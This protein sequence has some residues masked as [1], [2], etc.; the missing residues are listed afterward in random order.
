MDK[1]KYKSSWPILVMWLLSITFGSFQ[2]AA[3]TGLVDEAIQRLEQDFLKDSSH[4]VPDRQDVTDLLQ[5]IKETSS[6]AERIR[7]MRW[8]SVSPFWAASI[9][10]RDYWSMFLRFS[11]DDQPYALRYYTGIAMI[12]EENELIT[13]IFNQDLETAQEF[14]RFNEET[15]Q[16]YADLARLAIAQLIVWENE[17][18][19]VGDAAAFSTVFQPVSEILEGVFSE[20][21]AQDFLKPTSIVQDIS[22]SRRIFAVLSEGSDASTWSGLYNE[23]GGSASIAFDPA[24]GVEQVNSRFVNP[25]RTIADTVFGRQARLCSRTQQRLSQ[26]NNLFYK[27]ARGQKN[28]IVNPVYAIEQVCMGVAENLSIGRLAME[29]SNTE[30]RDYRVVVGHTR[31][32]TVRF[33]KQSIDELATSSRVM[34]ENYPG[35]RSAPPSEGLAHCRSGVDPS[36]FVRDAGVNRFQSSETKEGYI[37]IGQGLSRSEAVSVTEFVQND[38]AFRGAYVFRPVD[39]R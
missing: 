13:S 39:R 24:L 20:R 16:V 28:R 3:D 2:A 10:K 22:L 1:G 19:S 12:M 38:R 23:F 11:Q 26:S 17:D 6:E 4:C 31:G 29:V 21:D 30:N 5:A 18:V 33:S 8:L 36:F 27:L 37:Y 25:G 14:L 34:M 9:P 35:F 15:N 32:D 7:G